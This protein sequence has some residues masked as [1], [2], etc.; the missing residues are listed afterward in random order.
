MTLLPF[1]A[2]PAF[3]RDETLPHVEV[4]VHPA[5]QPAVAEADLQAAVDHALHGLPGPK[6]LPPGSRR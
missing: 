2:R 6:T 5:I 4:S 3:P 1:R